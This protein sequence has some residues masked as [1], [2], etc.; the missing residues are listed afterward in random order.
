[1]SEQTESVRRSSAAVTLPFKSLRWWSRG[2]T[3]VGLLWTGL[4]SV[5]ADADYFAQAFSDRHQGPGTVSALFD[6]A[7]DSNDGIAS[8]HAFATAGP[9]GLTASSRTTISSFH[10]NENDQITTG[11]RAALTLN[12]V[13]ITGPGSTIDFSIFLSV[14]GT[15]ATNVSGTGIMVADAYLSINGAVAYPTGAGLVTQMF[16]GN[17]SQTNVSGDIQRFTDGILAD[18]DITGAVTTTRLTVPLNS[19]FTLS[20]GLDVG[21]VARSIIGEFDK[22]VQLDALSDFTH[23]LTFAISGPV[24]DLPPGFTAN[25]PDGFIFDNQFIPPAL[26]PEPATIGLLGV[27]VVGLTTLRFSRRLLKRSRLSRRESSQGIWEHSDSCRRSVK[28]CCRDK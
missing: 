4:S 5:Q 7:R 25:S 12:D 28:R 21:A 1:M 16:D 9:N 15:F 11:A 13:I 8:S 26:V 18:H 3:V 19:P 20:L 23:T 2:I 22:P 10:T 17:I 24:F 27:G 6:F 14:S